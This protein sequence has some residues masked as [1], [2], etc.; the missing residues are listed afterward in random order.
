MDFKVTKNMQEEIKKTMDA[1][2]NIYYL[3]IRGELTPKEKEDITKE[4][5]TRTFN[6]IGI[7]ELNQII[8]NQL[9][10][11]ILEEKI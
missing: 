5:L 2:M 7:R 4:Y 1:E 9:M 3:L 8:G 11:E 10:Q 6:A